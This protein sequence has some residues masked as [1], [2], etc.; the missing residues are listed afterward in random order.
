LV[1]LI[2]F[3]I[4]AYSYYRAKRGA[5]TYTHS[6]RSFRRSAHRDSPWGGGGGGW[7]IGGGGGGGWGNSGGGGGGWSDGGSFGGGDFGGGGAG[8][9]W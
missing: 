8:G 4:F 5:A 9:D 7:I 2:V 6:G 3:L 1:F